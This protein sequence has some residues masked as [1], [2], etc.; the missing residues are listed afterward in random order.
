[1]NRTIYL[2][3]SMW[4]MEANLKHLAIGTAITITLAVLL[5]VFA[6]QYWKFETAV[7]GKLLVFAGVPAKLFQLGT[8]VDPTHSF[9]I[10]YRPG[11]LTFQIPMQYTQ[12]EPIVTIV[13]SLLLILA[14]VLLYK[15][16]RF[17]LPLKVVFFTISC[18]VII[19]LLYVTFVSPVPPHFIN[20]LTIDWQFS[21][22]LVLILAS[23]V[24]TW[25]IFPVKGSLG[26][27]LGWLAALLIFSTVWNIIRLAVVLATLYHAGSLPFIL[28]HYLAGIYIDFIYIIMFYSLA[29]G[30]LAKVNVSEVGW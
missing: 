22:I 14:G 10:F 26:I 4:K 24:F 29:I 19:T 9:P 15:T 7:I 11:G 2:H 3:R 18:L 13:I 27:K 12:I 20:R 23:M 8:A 30:S 1:M 21:G 25:A 5:V 17:P 28:L 6:G 16:N